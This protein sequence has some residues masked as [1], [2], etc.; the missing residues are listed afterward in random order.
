M[1][2]EEIFEGNKFIVQFMEVDKKIL[3]AGYIH[4]WSD[5]PFYYTTENSKEKVI[6]NIIKYSKYHSSYDWLMP[7]LRKILDITF[8][9]EDKETS[10]S[11]YFYDI[12]DC[13]PDIDSTYRAI[14]DF[15]KLYNT[16]KDA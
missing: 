4:S 9:D 11:S 1:T 7:V 6:H 8:S 10:D 14:V 13:L 3:S 12:R 15:I 2:K 16:K 5:P